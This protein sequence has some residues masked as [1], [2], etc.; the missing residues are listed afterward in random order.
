MLS[1]TTTITA[2][3][4]TATATTA[5]QL[6]LMSGIVVVVAELLLL[7]LHLQIQQLI[8]HVLL[9]LML[10]VSKA[11]CYMCRYHFALV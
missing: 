5:V 2:I 1:I 3:I 7:L 4:T 10:L 6:L 11:V 9:P 8:L